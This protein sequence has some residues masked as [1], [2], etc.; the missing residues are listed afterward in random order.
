M[1]L[2]WS[3]TAHRTEDCPGFDHDRRLCLI[4]PD[5]C[6]FSAAEGE[7]ELTFKSREAMTPDVSG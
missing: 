3:V 7:A 1:V 2:R 5:D 4:R 6:E